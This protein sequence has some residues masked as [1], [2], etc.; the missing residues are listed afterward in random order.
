[1]KKMQ[2]SKDI[3]TVITIAVITIS[4]AKGHFEMTFRLRNCNDGNC[5]H[6]TNTVSLSS[7][8]NLKYSLKSSSLISGDNKSANST[9]TVVAHQHQIDFTCSFGCVENVLNKV[10]TSPLCG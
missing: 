9:S 6:R 10:I 1:M 7:M 8:K 5:F 3:S 4:K 2:V